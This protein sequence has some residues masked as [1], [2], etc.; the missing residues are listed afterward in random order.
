VT[1]C[2]GPRAGEQRIFFLPFSLY[3]GFSLYFIFIYIG[4]SFFPFFVISL[5]Q[6]SNL[7]LKFPFLY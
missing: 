5:F 6:F 1:D 3:I 4:F 2:L 7:G